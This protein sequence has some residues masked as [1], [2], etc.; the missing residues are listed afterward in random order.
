MR[1]WSV[2]FSF[3]R[4]WKWLASRLVSSKSV[5]ERGRGGR[6]FKDMVVG[7]ELRGIDLAAGIESRGKETE[8]GSECECTGR[9]GLEIVKGELLA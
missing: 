9:E 6:S 7:L 1:E 5:G 8:G 4:A 2:A 3:C